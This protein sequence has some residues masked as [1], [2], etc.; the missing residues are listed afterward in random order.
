MN[1]RSA[2]AAEKNSYPS[3]EGSGEWIRH[4][5]LEKRT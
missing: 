1:D 3:G 2:I 4:S 5:A